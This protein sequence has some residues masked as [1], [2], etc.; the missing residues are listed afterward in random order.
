L[1]L[2]AVGGGAYYYLN[3]PSARRVEDPVS[4][5][6]DGGASKQLTEDAPPKLSG[7]FCGGVYMK[8]GTA[9]AVIDTGNGGVT[10]TDQL[11]V[12]SLDPKEV[13]STVMHRAVDRFTVMNRDAR[14]KVN[15]AYDVYPVLV[16]ENGV[17]TPAMLAV[18]GSRLYRGKVVTASGA[19]KD[20]P[21]GDIAKIRSG[22]YTGISPATPNYTPASSV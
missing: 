17:P 5:V 1:L 15:T 3:K 11:Q 21:Y 8:T 12:V 22:K 13:R 2:L 4:R 19:V 7:V 14:T 16:T 10:I 18:P 9:A 20:I 6:G